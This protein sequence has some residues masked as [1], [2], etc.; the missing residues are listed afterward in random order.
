MVRNQISGIVETKQWVLCLKLWSSFKFFLSTIN[1]ATKNNKLVFAWL[2]IWNSSLQADECCVQPE[3]GK[4]K[5][6]QRKGVLG[7]AEPWWP[8]ITSSPVKLSCHRKVL[9]HELLNLIILFDLLVGINVFRTNL[10]L[11][12]KQTGERDFS[13]VCQYKSVTNV[14]Q[15][16]LSEDDSKVPRGVFRA[17][18]SL[19]DCCL[20]CPVCSCAALLAGTGRG[21]SCH[22]RL[23]A[24]KVTTCWPD[25]PSG[26]GFYLVQGHSWTYSLR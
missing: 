4:V 2:M 13:L 18:K 16:G 14:L 6:Q 21:Q 19:Q 1:A 25:S 24:R 9:K 12:W 17:W 3:E 20:C 22:S 23:Q 5:A 8:K 15:H 26:P 11:T 10:A 7:R